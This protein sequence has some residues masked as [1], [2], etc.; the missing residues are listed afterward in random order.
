MDIEDIG[1]LEQKMMEIKEKL[2]GFILDSQAITAYLLG[3]TGS[4]K[5]TLTNYIL[6]ANLTFKKSKGKYEITN[7]SIGDYPAIGNT[8]SSCTDIPSIFKA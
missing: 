3:L 2:K 6:G 5:S 4:G 1:D 8:P 7:E